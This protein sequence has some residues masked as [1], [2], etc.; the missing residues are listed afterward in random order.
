MFDAD[1]LFADESDRSPKTLADIKAIASGVGVTINRKY[2][3]PFDMVLDLKV[4]A[5][6]NKLIKIQN[7]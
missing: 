6:S 7:L 2:D 3:K 4:A 5:A 1:F